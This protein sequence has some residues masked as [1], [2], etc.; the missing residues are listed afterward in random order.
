MKVIRLPR[1][2]EPLTREVWVTRF[3]NLW[4]ENQRPQEV[5]T[6]YRDGGANVRFEFPSGA[7]LEW[8]WEQTGHDTAFFEAKDYLAKFA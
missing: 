6:G 8:R 4:P 1:G 5:D 7:V 2:L 3:R